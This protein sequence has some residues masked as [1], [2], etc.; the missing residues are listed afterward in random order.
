MADTIL[1]AETAEQALHVVR[2][3]MTRTVKRDG[4]V[5]YVLRDGGRVTDRAG[6]IEVPAESRAAAI[7]ALD[8]AQARFGSCK[9]RVNGSME[10]RRRLIEAAAMDGMT[11]MFADPELETC[12]QEAMA[13]R[14]S[15]RDLEDVAQYVARR[16]GFS[17]NRSLLDYRS[18]TPEHAGAFTFEGR[19]P[20]R[21][22]THAVMWRRGKEVI[23][24][25]ETNQ[26][27]Q[28]TQHLSPGDKAVLGTDGW[29]WVDQG[30]GRW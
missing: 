19:A 12:R 15:S 3:G 11:V 13:R 10:F 1:A 14:S 30:H 25:R 2:L 5:A 21:D 6:T 27:R 29:A 7:F 22:G 23:V 9:L 20:L 24:Q 26:V 17:T 18:W 4:S 28:D 16:Q 8:L